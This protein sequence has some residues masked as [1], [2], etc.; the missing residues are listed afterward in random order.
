MM[1]LI[2]YT[3]DGVNPSENVVDE[4]KFVHE[5]VKSKDV[6]K[7]TKQLTDEGYRIVCVDRVYEK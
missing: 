3:F 5:S 4:Q 6:L 1:Y 7:R 2:T